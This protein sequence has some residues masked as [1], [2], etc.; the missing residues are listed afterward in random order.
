VGTV[1]GGLCGA[2]MADAGSV[3]LLES[4]VRVEVDGYS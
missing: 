2:Q 3:K 4:V 1:D